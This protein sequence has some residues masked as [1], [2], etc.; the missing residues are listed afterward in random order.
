MLCVSGGPR[1]AAGEAQYPAT[2]SAQVARPTPGARPSRW[3]G[4]GN[5]APAASNVRRAFEAWPAQAF[6]V[7]AYAALSAV[8]STTAQTLRALTYLADLGLTTDV[9]NDED[10]APLRGA[11]PPRGD[12]PAGGERRAA[13]E[14]H[15]G[16]HARRGGFLSGGMSHDSGAGVWYVGSIRHRK[17]AR[18]A[19]DGSVHDIVREG[20]DGLWAVI[21]GPA[22][23]APARSGSAPPRSRRWRLCSADSGRA[24]ISAFDLS[25]GRMEG[26]LPA[27]RLGPGPCAGDL[28]VAPN[29][30]S[31]P[32]TAG[33]RRDWRIRKGSEDVQEY[34]RHPLFRS[35]QGPAIDPI[36]PDMYVA[37]YSHGCSRWTEH[38]NGVRAPH[39]APDHRAGDR[40][41]RL[42]RRL[43]DRVQNGIARARVVR[44][45]LDAA[46]SRITAVEV[47]DLH[48]PI[49]VERPSARVG[50][51]LL[52]VA[53]SQWNRM[54]RVGAEGGRSS[55][56]PK[57]LGSGC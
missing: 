26:S 51:P 3:C 19:R 40:P 54:T 47:L 16:R 9:A 11:R 8:C 2:D 20:Q 13:G 52:Y 12:P 25:T 48:L 27:A 4:A 35:L 21:G 39:A 53:N 5:G 44:L 41:S 46:G 7:T 31:M 6:Y 33:I 14:E 15:R 50:E 18:I 56:P 30:A 29:G 22:D 10:L 32:P 37:E 45:A 42:A 28:V 55:H 24:G 23:P 36:G 34:L 38:P 43:A 1:R 49:A 57:I 17:V